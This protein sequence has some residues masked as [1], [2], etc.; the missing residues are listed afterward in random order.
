M[1]L[2]LPGL[3]VILTYL[4]RVSVWLGTYATGFVWSQSYIINLP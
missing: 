3:N 2:V 4:D 1:P